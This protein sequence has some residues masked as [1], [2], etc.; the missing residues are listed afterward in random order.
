MKLK[1]WGIIAAVFI[2]ALG[3]TSLYRKVHPI[4]PK[5]VGKYVNQTKPIIFEVGNS[6]KTTKGDVVLYPVEP[7]YDFTLLIPSKST[8]I[9]AKHAELYF[10]DKKIKVIG[11]IEQIDKNY[12]VTVTRRDQ[13]K[14]LK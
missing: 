7:G 8:S 10:L 13:I 5:Q 9:F 3:L 14:Q 1:Q 6:F 11:K 4:G 12:Q 2:A